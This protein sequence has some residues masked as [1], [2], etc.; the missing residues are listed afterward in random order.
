MLS[1]ATCS[2]ILAWAS[3]GGDDVGPHLGE[4]VHVERHVV[5]L[6]AEVGHRRVHVVVELGEAVH[7]VPDVPH[8]G[9]EDV[10][11]VPVDVDALD[12]LGVYV[13]RDVVAAIDDE[14]GLAGL[15]CGVG[16]DGS[17]QAGTDDEVVVLGHV[18]LLGRG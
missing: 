16:E 1:A 6:A 13:A 9:V 12:L 4:R 5:H 10:G 18:G 14:D 3:T 11:A 7:V 15:A 2:A 17:G 8:R